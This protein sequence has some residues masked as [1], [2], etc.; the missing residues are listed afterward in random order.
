MLR[1]A[2]GG[3]TRT[4]KKKFNH[5][6]H[7]ACVTTRNGNN[8]GVDFPFP[9]TVFCASAQQPLPDPQ[10]AVVPRFH[11]ATPVQQQQLCLAAR[12]DVL[13]DLSGAVTFV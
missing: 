9:S 2:E 11:P 10:T 6:C 3:S 4:T 7:H 1:G 13:Q 8:H 5:C 12:A